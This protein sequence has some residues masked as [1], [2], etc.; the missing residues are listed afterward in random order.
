[1]VG[2]YFVLKKFFFQIFLE[3]F[4]HPF[5]FEINPLEQKDQ[6]EEIFLYSWRWNILCKKKSSKSPI[7]KKNIDESY[8][9]LPKVIILKTVQ[10]KKKTREMK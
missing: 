8:S 6:M 9:Q 3:K 1:M 4:F 5:F 7:R 2:I 10:S